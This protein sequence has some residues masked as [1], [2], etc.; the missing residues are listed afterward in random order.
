MGAA[1]RAF[2]RTH[3]SAR[4]RRAFVKRQRARLKA[5]QRAANCTV[6]SPTPP[7]PPPPPPR[8]DLS[9]TNTAFPTSVLLGTN[10]LTFTFVVANAGPAAASNVTLIDQFSNFVAKRWTMSQSIGSCSGPTAVTCTV[11]SIPSGSSVTLTVAGS[12]TAAGAVSNT[13]SVSA[14]LSTDSNSANNSA[15]STATVVG[16]PPPIVFSGSGSRVHDVTL[17]IDSPAVVSGTHTGT[18]NF[19][20]KL[21]APQDTFGDLLFNEIGSFAGETVSDKNTP[22]PYKLEVQADGAWTIR[23]TQPLPNDAAATIPSTFQ[24][25][26]QKV[27]PI[28]V[29]Q[30]MQPTVTG[31]HNGTSNFIVLLNGYG[32]SKGYASLLFNEIGQFQGQRLIAS[33]PANPYLLEV[34]ADGVWS[35]T[36]AP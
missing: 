13:V 10:N 31:S 11:Q 16:E 22:G 2:F 29:P 3:R 9:V 8:A 25:T 19:I 33:L 4:A 6:A 30:D 15:T 20:V 23:I 18:S 36:F 14:A 17:T 28:L 26:G 21:V 1:K 27:I 32:D 24:G 7:P 12:P 5:L 35:L 34:D